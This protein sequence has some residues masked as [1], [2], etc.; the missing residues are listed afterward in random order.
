MVMGK[1]CQT[2][3]IAAFLCAIWLPLLDNLIGLDTTTASAEKRILAPLP[4]RP[5]DLESLKEFPAQFEAYYND[6]FGFRN[7]LI[8]L[9]NLVLWKC[10]GDS[11]SKRVIVGKG[12]WL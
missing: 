1:I 12:T 11:V 7:K 9:N 2:M 8:F 4:G 10:F 5:E 6:H 3:L